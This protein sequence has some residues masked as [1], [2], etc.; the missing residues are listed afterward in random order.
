MLMKKRLCIRLRNIDFKH[1]QRPRKFFS[2]ASG[3]EH[4]Y[5]KPSMLSLGV[6][7][8]LILESYFFLVVLI[9]LTYNVANKNSYFSE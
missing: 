8:G 2:S 6:L 9:E 7:K 5:A 3:P 4:V 1:V